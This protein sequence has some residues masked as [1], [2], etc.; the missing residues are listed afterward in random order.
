VFLSPAG[1]LLNQLK[2]REL[3]R[4][5]RITLVCGH[6][7]GIDQRVVDR[8]ADEQ[9]S[10]GDYVLTGG[11]VAAAVLID[12]VTREIEEAL[13]NNESRSEESFDSTGLL[14][15]EHYTRPAEF[16]GSGVPAVLRSGNHGA[17]A[18]WRLRRRLANTLNTRPELFARIALTRE[19]K[20]ILEE[21][22]HE[23]GKE[24]NHEPS[25]GN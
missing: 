3:A 2:V 21:I 23:A 15:Y 24:T 25:A 11:E 4:L 20:G 13:G 1:A 19:M 5:D 18:R 6:Y 7:E 17:I 16:E 9:I 10:V 12:S 14:E 8:F 22:R